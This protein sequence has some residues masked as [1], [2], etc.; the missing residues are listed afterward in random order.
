MNSQQRAKH[1]QKH[2]MVM[3]MGDWME[4]VRN[5]SEQ[6]DG[7]VWVKGKSGK[8]SPQ[9]R[10]WRIQD[11]FY[12]RDWPMVSAIRKKTLGVKEGY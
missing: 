11:F 1:D 12:H 10:K 6:S 4:N 7:C 2:V 5:K 8:K 9:A 3:Q